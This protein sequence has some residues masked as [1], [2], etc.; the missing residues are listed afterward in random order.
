MN[1]IQSPVLHSKCIFKEAISH[2][3]VG[4]L[5]PIIKFTTSCGTLPPAG[6]IAAHVHT[7]IHIKDTKQTHTIKHKQRHTLSRADSLANTVSHDLRAR[8]L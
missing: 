4:I 2:R 6:A 3:T 5:L 1:R 7:H 8:M